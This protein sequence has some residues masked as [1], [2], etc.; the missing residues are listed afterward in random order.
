MA[1]KKEE[2]AIQPEKLNIW[3]K[4]AKVRNEA[5][6]KKTGVNQYGGY[7]YFELPAIYAEAKKLFAKYGLASIFLMERIAENRYQGKLTVINADNPDEKIELTLETE[8]LEETF[9]ID[10]K[11]G[12]K[13]KSMTPPQE[14]GAVMTYLRKYLYA[15]LMMLDDGATDPDRWAAPDEIVKHAPKKQAPKYEPK[16]DE[17]KKRAALIRSCASLFTA[18]KIPPIEAHEIIEKWSKGK[19]QSIKE[20]PLTTL[21]EF[22]QYLSGLKEVKDEIAK[23]KEKENKEEPENIEPPKDDLPEIEAEKG[24]SDVPF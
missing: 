21:I 18:M 3:Q 7:S 14:T 19:F 16:D 8:G 10:R 23:E 5:S 20:M 4:I 12:E 24:D 11:T 13:K 17:K 1:N 9:L 6:V 2:K 22:E 15:D